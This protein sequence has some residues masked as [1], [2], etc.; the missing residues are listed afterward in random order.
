MFPEAVR[1]V[2]RMKVNNKIKKII[3]DEFRSNVN[4]FVL[5]GVLL[6]ALGAVSVICRL[7]F[8]KKNVSSVLAGVSSI[9]SVA[10]GII[11]IVGG[12]YYSVCKRKTI[13]KNMAEYSFGVDAAA[14]AAVLSLPDPIVIVEK[15]G[16]IQWCNKEFNKL[17]E[18]DELLGC[19]L[20]EIFP[21]IRTTDFEEEKRVAKPFSYNGRDFMLIGKTTYSEYE[22]NASELIS[23]S[24]ADISEITKL[25]NRFDEK[26]TVVCT[27]VI[28]NY[29]EVLKETPNSSHGV[30]IGD[31]ERCVGL[32]VEKGNGFYRKYERDKFIILFESAGFESLLAEKFSLLNDIKE[33]E[34]QNKIPVTLSI[35]VG[36]DSGDIKE[37]DRLSLS[38][39]DMALGRGGDQAVVKSDE[40]YSFYGAKSLGVEKTTKVKARVV[41]KSLCA[42]IDK[43]SNVIIMGH[44]GSDFDSFGTAAGLF[45]AVK[46]RNKK[47]CIALDRNHNN[48]GVL[49]KEALIRPEYNEGIVSYDRAVSMIGLNTLLIVIDTH[50]PSMVE[51]PDIL[52]RV[53][54]VVLID[55]HRRSEEFIENTVLT[56]HE[57]YASSASE[58]VTEML[59]YTEDEKGLS[60]LEAEALYCGIYLDTKGFT[61]KTGARTFEAAAYLRKMGVD[62]VRV[63]KLFRNDIS[64]YVLKSNIIGRT[65]IYRD[66]IAISVC[67]EVSKNLQLIV[68][69]AADDLLNISGVEASFV[70]ALVGSKVIIS[71]RS[72]GGIN[73]QVILEKLGGGG[74]ST[75]AGAQLENTSITIAELKLQNA[76]DEALYD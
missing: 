30:L 26:Q 25:R 16:T 75:I 45:R 53:K 8:F 56:Y 63:H 67:D 20:Q 28:D 59:Q 1:E 34:Q 31:V 54:N 36:M 5:C 49:L 44:K 60:L 7:N 70:L 65:K 76:I 47:V 18:N 46:N 32:W 55:H 40:G 9:I 66:N 57:P 12:I 4:T 15:T 38:A 41:A 74:H 14:K 72:L 33:I 51:Y 6:I 29:D 37:N 24:F 13:K 39:L 61:F 50:R 43:A 19:K 69:Q 22:N 58:M 17:C 62:P 64:T 23:I 27:A 71:G 42:L 11:V 35:G 2:K 21:S 48:V 68:A 3:N 52:S 10:V 73:V